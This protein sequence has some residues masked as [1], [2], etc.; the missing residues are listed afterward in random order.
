MGVSTKIT[1]I[2]TDGGYAMTGNRCKGRR[3]NLQEIFRADQDSFKE[4]WR[5]VCRRSWPRR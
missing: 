5:E 1:L 4:F 2:R 3:I